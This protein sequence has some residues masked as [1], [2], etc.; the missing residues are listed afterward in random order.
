MP[1]RNPELPNDIEGNPDTLFGQATPIP[2]GSMVQEVVNIDDS[3]LHIERTIIP[4]LKATRRRR[5]PAKK[6]EQPASVVE[7][8]DTSSAQTD[9]PLGDVEP[10]FSFPPPFIP[11]P[12]MPPP[13]LSADQEAPPYTIDSDENITEVLPRQD[14]VETEGIEELPDGYLWDQE[15]PNLIT[16][17]KHAENVVIEEE[18]LHVRPAYSR[19]RRTRVGIGALLAVGA[20]VGSLLIF[21][22]GE[23]DNNIMDIPAP[24]IQ[25]VDI[26][27][28]RAGT[29]RYTDMIGD[30][31]DRRELLE[32]LQ[33]HTIED[34][35]NPR[36]GEPYYTG[37]TDSEYTEEVEIAVENFQK[38]AAARNLYTAKPDGEAGAV[39][40]RAIAAYDP[41]FIVQGG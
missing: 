12:P 41:E 7:A 3:G 2:E 40:C 15:N 10:R 37:D 5:A 21:S 31:T 4:P 34:P 24:S 38:D 20:V 18:K 6:P 22:S 23:E 17:A 30:D 28:A 11:A 39:T 32:F 9:E 25:D 19:D 8:S 33:E 14:Y 29:C 27:E 13:A 16:Q 36:V 1:G 26:V 35:S